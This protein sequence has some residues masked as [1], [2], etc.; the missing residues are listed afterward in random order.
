MS[1]TISRSDWDCPVCSQPNSAEEVACICCECPV[2]CTGDALAQRRLA[3]TNPQPDEISSSDTAQAA[4][5]ISSLPM[6]PS[7]K[8]MGIFPSMPRVSHSIMVFAA[9]YFLLLAVAVVLVRAF[10]LEPDVMSSAVY[11][12]M[13]A[14]AT[15]VGEYW[16]RSN[17]LS[18]LR[19]EKWAVIWA[20]FGI[21]LLADLMAYMFRIDLHGVQ[22]FSSLV[23]Q[24]IAHLGFLWLA[25]GTNSFV[26]DKSGPGTSKK[27]VS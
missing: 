18:A 8:Y 10:E 27:T 5:T 19:K 17:M 14:A 3:F 23:M 2:Q 21:T 22:F 6:V 13:I 12:V 25:L 11:G 26:S 16:K 24:K 9:L 20:C 15:A 7:S 1:V 4:D